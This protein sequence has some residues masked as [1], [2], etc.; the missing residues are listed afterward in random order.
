MGAVV[1]AAVAADQS[2]KHLARAALRGAGTVQV[3]GDFFILRYAEN[4]GAFL[5]LGSSWPPLWRAAVFGIFSLCVVVAAAVYGIRQTGLSR[6]QTAALALVIGG[7]AGNLI[8]RLARGGLVTDFMNV[9]IGTLRT[10]IFNL[11]DL[12]LMAGAVLVALGL[13]SRQER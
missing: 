10:G 4:N 6:F 5:S 12:F 2:T 13:R 8:D 1:L 3:V 7:G 11:A 9:G